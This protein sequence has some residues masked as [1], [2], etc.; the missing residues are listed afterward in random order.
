MD[1]ARV[2]TKLG[3]SLSNCFALDLHYYLQRQQYIQ[4]VSQREDDL[5]DRIGPIRSSRPASPYGSSRPGSGYA[6]PREVREEKWRQEA[7]DRERPTKN[8]MRE[9]YKELGGRKTRGKSKFGGVTRDKGGWGDGGG[10]DDDF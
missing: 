6:T 2:E 7:E 9:M 3:T 5:A 4:T 8:E 10:F 1:S